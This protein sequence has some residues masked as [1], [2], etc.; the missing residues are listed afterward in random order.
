MSAIKARLYIEGKE[1]VVDH[2]YY[3]M[4]QR[5]DNTNWPIS[6]PKNA[7]IELSIQAG[8]DSLFYEWSVSPDM[9]KECKLVFF[10]SNPYT[11]GITYELWDTHCVDYR[12][13]FSHSGSDPMYEHL[14]L[15]PA[16]IFRNKRLLI[17]HYWRVRDPKEYGKVMEVEIAPI[18]RPYALQEAKGQPKLTSYYFEDDTGKR[19][20]A[21]NLRHGMKIN[22]TQVS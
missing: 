3:Y 1:F 7:P 20:K 17:S 2:F 4:G 9:I 22:L 11:K 6:R 10:P 19:I 12:S 5:M 14:L 13:T 21:K 16:T 8:E 15:S 18:E